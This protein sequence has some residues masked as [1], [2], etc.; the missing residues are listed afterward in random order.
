[1]ASIRL[2]LALVYDVWWVF[3]QPAVFGGESVMV[4]VATGA[5]AGAALPML[6]AFPRASLGTNPGYSI[7]GLGDVVLPGL[8]AAFAARWDA[9]RGVGWAQGY[10]VPC[11]AAYAAGL[12][13]TWAALAASLF[14]GEGQPALLYLVPATLGTVLALAAARGDLR[15][16][17]AA[18]PP[19]GGPAGG[20]GA[21]GPEA[22][23]LLG[24]EGVPDDL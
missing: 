10:A 22:G 2:P 24:E 11:C 7:L 17:W 4:A 15:R 8:L 23:S 9:A 3:I 20:R 21:G 19:G 14:G 18:E 1:M 13:A 6:L 12:V 16:M 5:G